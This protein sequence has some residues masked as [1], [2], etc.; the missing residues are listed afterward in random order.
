MGKEHFDYIWSDRK[1]TI[2]GLPLS[3]TKYFLTKDKFITRKGFLSISEDECELYRITDKR[4]KL[5]FM[6]RLFKCG[7]IYLHV[8]NDSDTPIKEVHAIKNPRDFMKLLEEYVNAERDKYNIRGRDMLGSDM[9][10]P[11]MADDDFG[12]M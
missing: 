6:Q 8:K 9:H 4:L 10:H 2:F 1:R 5:P 3:F 12:N 11:E 7:T